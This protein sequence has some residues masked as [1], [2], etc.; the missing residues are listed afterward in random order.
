MSKFTWSV[1]VWAAVA[2]ATFTGPKALA[3]DKSSEAPA[4]EERKSEG[5]T[6]EEH[7]SVLDEVIVTSARRR[8]ES[9]QTTP[10]AVTALNDVL[11]E[12]ARVESSSDLGKLAPSLQTAKQLATADMVA[13]YL[14]GFGVATDDP[15]LEP[16]VAIYIDGGYQPHVTGTMIDLFD[17]EKV[18]V[19]RGPQ[20]TIFGKNAPSGAV[21]ITTKRPS[22]T[23]DAKMQVD[24]GRFDRVEARLRLDFPIF[25]DVLA[26]KVFVIK[27]HG[28]NYIHNLT[29]NKDVGGDDIKAGRLG[30][31]FTP[32]HMFDWYLSVSRS[33]NTSPQHGIRDQTDA[34]T[35]PLFLPGGYLSCAIYLHCNPALNPPYTTRS[36][37]ADKNDINITDL[38]SEMN[39]RFAPATLTAVTAYRNYNNLNSED[40]DGEPEQILEVSGQHIRYHM[41]SQEFRLGSAAGGGWNFGDRIDWVVGAYYFHE[42]FDYDRVLDVLV[43]AVL[44]PFRQ[45]QHGKSDSRAAFGQVNYKLTEQWKLSFGGRRTWDNKE[46]QIRIPRS[47]LDVDL[48]APVSK[49]WSNTSIEAGVQYQLDSNKMFY[50]RYAE[51]YRGGGFVGI[52]PGG[53][54]TEISYNPEKAK[55]YEV[56]AKLDWF[57]RRVRTNLALYRSNYSDLQRSIVQPTTAPPF[58]A[59]LTANAAKGRVEGMEL[60][61]VF[62]PIAPLTLK[63]NV[64]YIN[65]KYLSFFG[66]ATGSGAGTPRDN[67]DFAW[68]YTPRWSGLL[69]A[70]YVF[71]TSFGSVTLNTNYQ[72]RAKMY[73]QDLPSPDALVPS[74]GLVDASIRFQTLNERYALTLYGNNLTNKYYTNSLTTTNGI[75]RLY[76]DELP[77]TWGVSVSAQF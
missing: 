40:A 56:G 22:G 15:A 44:Q 63:L 11:L 37:L 53:T 50:F 25:Q 77:R 70:D 52:P 57:D 61:S 72:Y 19:L 39:V 45:R 38:S 65:A 5:T 1:G 10:V 24:Y 21:N 74:L 54:T 13:M 9:V 55:S 7:K 6:A 64:A 46:H 62:V 73:A 32:T 68:G 59:L 3:Q 41:F 69:G 30:L 18:E 47:L 71:D 34:H 27:K 16:P 2:A 48:S 17:V 26:G 14:R 43:P 20:G 8:E 35:D 29:L 60:E 36:A 42:E 76:N 49:K 28:G 75:T 4:A 66:D 31:L 58:Y 12:K 67:T 51:A 33:E 23:W